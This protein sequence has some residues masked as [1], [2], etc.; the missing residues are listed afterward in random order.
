MI[1]RGNRNRLWTGFFTFALAHM[2]KLFGAGPVFQGNFLVQQTV[3][4]PSEQPS[5]SAVQCCLSI[6]ATSAEIAQVTRTPVQ[7]ITGS[8]FPKKFEDADDKY[9]RAK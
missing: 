1:K 5:S 8:R 7:S 4:P 6:L 2:G 9:L 3:Q